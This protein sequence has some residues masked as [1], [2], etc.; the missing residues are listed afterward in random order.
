VFSFGVISA[1]LLIA[2]AATG[3]KLKFNTPDNKT[4]YGN[5]N[6]NGLFPIYM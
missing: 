1:V 3:G 2:D 5:W 4:K 6:P